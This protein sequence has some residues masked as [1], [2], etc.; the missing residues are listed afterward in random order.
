MY[1]QKTDKNLF[2]QCTDANRQRMNLFAT[3]S[4]VNDAVVSILPLPCL[5]FSITNVISPQIMQNAAFNYFILSYDEWVWITAPDYV[6]WPKC[7]WW[8]IVTP[9]NKSGFSS[10]LMVRIVILMLKAG[11]GSDS[12]TGNLSRVPNCLSRLP[13]LRTWRLS[14][15]GWASERRV[16]A[17]TSYKGASKCF[18]HHQTMSSYYD[19]V[20]VV[21]N[22][23][24]GRQTS[25]LLTLHL[26]PCLPATLFYKLTKTAKPDLLIIHPVTLIVLI[27]A[28]IRCA[29]WRLQLRLYRARTRQLSNN[30]LASRPVQP[31]GPLAI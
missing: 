5:V 30:S 18:Q 14:R 28:E 11:A 17:V 3:D 23:F 15:T 4:M 26:K 27:A 21:T 10:I 25:C 12:N 22:I 13:L 8:V 2:D 29:L 31:K 7:V 6:M 19:E 20:M 16:W 9:W 24:H 1:Q